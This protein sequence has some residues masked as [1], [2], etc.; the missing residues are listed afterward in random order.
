MSQ[1]MGVTTREE[2]FIRRAIKAGKSWEEIAPDLVDVD[3]A[4]VHENIYEPLATQ[5]DTGVD[6]TALAPQPGDLSKPSGAQD[7]PPPGD[8][9]PAPPAGTKPL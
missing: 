4:Y 7:G 8:T 9:P 3:L 6:I 2:F 5:H 1:R